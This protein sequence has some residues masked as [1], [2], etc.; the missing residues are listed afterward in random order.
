MDFDD[1]TNILEFELKSNDYALANQVIN[2]NINGTSFTVTTDI[3]GKAYKTLS[4]YAPG[5]YIV[6]YSYLG[7]DKVAGANRT[8]TIIIT[9][10]SGKLN[11]EL[12]M[13]FDDDTNILEFD[14]SINDQAL[15]NQVINVNING[16]SFTVT[17]NLN[18]KAYMTLT[19][20]TPGQYT[21]N[22]SYLGTDKVSGINKTETIIISNSSKS[23]T[24][25]DMDFDDDTNILEFDL[26]YNNKPLANKTIQVNINGTSFT[27]TTNTYGKAYMTLSNYTPGQYTVKYYLKEIILTIQ[28]VELKVYILIIVQGLLVEYMVKT[29]Q[30]FMDHLKITLENLLEMMETL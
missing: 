18:G 23:S 21:V 30:W 17:T 13:D 8:E 4:N 26:N 15:A 6:S 28:V 12:D 24:D 14:L 25:L 27:L 3:N 9:N 19:N 29:L 7:T 16:T 22:Y 5:Y 10:S 2:V 1:D 20:Y 11:T